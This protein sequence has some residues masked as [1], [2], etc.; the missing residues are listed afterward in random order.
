MGTA[1]RRFRTQRS[2]RKQT[3]VTC[4]AYAKPVNPRLLRATR[5][6]FL[7]SCF[8]ESEGFRRL[9][10]E[11]MGLGESEKDAGEGEEVVT[12]SICFETVTTGGGRSMAL[13]QC[14]HQFHL[15]RFLPL[16]FALVLVIVGFRNYKL[17]LFGSV[18]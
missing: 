13:L 14:G 16:Q 18:S 11:R 4:G 12:C 8:L 10:H 5:S 3:D 1:I 6:G 2:M 7:P 9:G 15:G 17:V